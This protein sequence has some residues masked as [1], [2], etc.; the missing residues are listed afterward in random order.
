MRATLAALVVGLTLLG[1]SSEEKHAGP[2]QRTAAP[3]GI[4]EAQETAK[5][6]RAKIDAAS[7][8][9][10]ATARF[11]SFKNL[12]DR[13]MDMQAVASAVHDVLAGGKVDFPADLAAMGADA[14]PPA[15]TYLVAGKIES[16]RRS[17]PDGTV[18]YTSVDLQLVDAKANGIVLEARQDF[19]SKR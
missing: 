10:H 5:A 6:L 14:P 15:T 12:T 9:A 18:V 3:Y 11:L 17:G 2:E 7:L 13:S 4:T 19:E 8:P 16:T 1:C